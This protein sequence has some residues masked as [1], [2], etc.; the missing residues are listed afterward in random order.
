MSRHIRS[1][2]SFLTETPKVPVDWI[3]KSVEKMFQN[4]TIGNGTLKSFCNIISVLI[5]TSGSTNNVN[6]GRC[7]RGRG[8]VDNDFKA[9]SGTDPIIAAEIKGVIHYLYEMSHVYNL[10]DVVLQIHTFSNDIEF[11]GELTIDSH[12]NL[13]K[14]LQDLPNIMK[15]SFGGTNLLAGVKKVCEDELI[16]KNNTHIVIASDGHP[17]VEAGPDQIISYLKGLP[18][19]V[20]QNLSVALIGAGSIQLSQ[21]GGFG[22]RSS[23]SRSTGA[24]FVLNDES[25]NMP[26][27]CNN[28]FGSVSKTITECNIGFLLEIMNIMKSSVY[29][30]AFGDYSKLRETA[31]E[32]FNDIL[33]YKN[34]VL[35]KVVLDTGSPVVLPENIQYGL[36]NSHAVIGYSPVP[37]SW[38]LYTKKWQVALELDT[39]HSAPSVDIIFIPDIKQK[40]F[41][42]TYDDEYSLVL[43]QQGKIS[44]T[45]PDHK[46]FTSVDSNGFWRCRQ[47]IV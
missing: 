42:I 38:Y 17:N 3:N 15:Y 24:I 41:I 19:I 34:N 26:L 16:L 1:C 23:G 37:K 43:Y 18:E 47:I 30:P 40:D 12:E 5:D 13:A 11:V 2:S 29:L 44:V 6:S 20:Y 33:T 32:Y 4:I 22:I 25:F 7:I 27:L 39:N 31:R 21:G 14:L 36:N 8:S 10:K 28:L 46:F 35:Y 45:C 9:E